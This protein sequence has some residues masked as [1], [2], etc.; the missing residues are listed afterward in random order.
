MPSIRPESHPCD[1][2]R[3]A[4]MFLHVA[5][6]SFDINDVI[7]FLLI[8]RVLGIIASP[9]CLFQQKVTRDTGAAF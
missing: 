1:R 8:F 5:L 6:I 2:F 9:R 7:F 4:E 3:T